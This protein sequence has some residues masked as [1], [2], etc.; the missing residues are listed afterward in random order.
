VFA[1]VVILSIGTVVVHVVRAVK[2]R[3]VKFRAGQ[4]RSPLWTL[5]PTPE[6]SRSSRRHSERRP[7][8]RIPRRTQMITM[9]LVREPTGAPEGPRPSLHPPLATRSKGAKA[10]NLTSTFTPKLA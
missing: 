9:R 5:K 10:V 8:Q 1:L 6:A 2:P 3:R 7:V 4:G